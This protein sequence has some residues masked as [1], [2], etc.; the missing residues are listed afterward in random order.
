MSI[1]RRDLLR[2]TAGV[3]AAGSLPLVL[4]AGNA[5]AASHP[6]LRTGSQG[7]AVLALQRRL[8][9]LGYWL[10]AADGQFGDL[11]RQAVVAVQKVAGLARDGVCGPATWA[12]VDAGVR[13]AARTTEGGVVE[14]DKKT[15]TLLVVNAGVVRWVFNTSTGSGRKYRQGGKDHVAVTPSGD[16]RVFRRVDGWD[17]GPLGKLYRPQYFNGG[18][19]VHGYPV[20][21]STPESHGC[22]RVSLPG[23]DF[24]WGAGGMGVGTRVL[25]R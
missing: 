18:I 10:G 15:Q 12:R 6:T 8:T 1:S 22:C 9:S 13:P 24:L 21:P 23:M 14:I 17:D 20:V 2:G 7:A 3:A 16:F 5:V 11:T 25:V 4:G 19:A